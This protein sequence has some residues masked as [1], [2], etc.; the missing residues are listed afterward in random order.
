MVMNDKDVIRIS[1][2][3]HPNPVL[4][5]NVSR[6][7]EGTVT[8]VSQWLEKDAA[9]ERAFFVAKELSKRI[10][11]GEGVII[12]TYSSLNSANDEIIRLRKE[13]FKVR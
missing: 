13:L 8:S 12:N 3:G 4:V 11:G 5:V 10:D 9:L 2:D 1:M 6:Q 7:I